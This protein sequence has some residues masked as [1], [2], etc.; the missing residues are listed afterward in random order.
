MTFQASIANGFLPEGFPWWVVLPIQS[1]EPGAW[2]PHTHRG[3][4]PGTEIFPV[5]SRP[6]G[7]CNQNGVADPD[8]LA[9]GTSE[10]CN[11]DGMPDECQGL[12]DRNGN[13]VPDD[14][15]ILSGTSQDR[16]LSGIPTSASGAR[17]G[18]PVRPRGNHLR[19]NDPWQG[20]RSFPLRGNRC[21]REPRVQ[22][23]SAAGA[24][25]SCDWRRIEGRLR[26]VRPV[27]GAPEEA[28]VS[29]R[30]YRYDL[31]RR[32]RRGDF[33]AGVQPVHGR[34]SG[35]ALRRGAG[36]R[37]GHQSRVDVPNG[38]L[39]LRGRLRERQG[40]HAHRI[41]VEDGGH[42]PPQEIGKSF[43]TLVSNFDQAQQAIG[44]VDPVRPARASSPP[45]A[46]RE[47]TRPGIPAHPPVA[48]LLSLRSSPWMRGAALERTP[49]S[50]VLE[51]TQGYLRV[52]QL[53]GNSNDGRRPP[54]TPRG[55]DMVLL[56]IWRLTVS[57][58]STEAPIPSRSSTGGS[59]LG[60]PAGRS[61]G[62]GKAATDFSSFAGAALLE[63]DGQPFLRRSRAFVS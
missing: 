39:L 45:S 7:D 24:T 46:S 22:P 25:R 59:T 26:E 43:V 21:L 19:T 11:A 36:W 29:A 40:S 3:L 48:A 50:P 53:Q 60:Y 1:T 41:L 18:L 56:E 23:R 55:E 58:E 20:A 4:V 12:S 27:R 61:V 32:I 14:C 8:D 5:A 54:A 31:R 33:S 15:D 51:V 34:R 17:Q 9:A 38:P 35:P 57:Q 30:L 42:G 2:I 44:D 6:P 62:R 49:A 13:G 10:D 28:A 63:V 52:H 47:G 16:D 37:R